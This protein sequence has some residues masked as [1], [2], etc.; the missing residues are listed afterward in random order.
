M[1]VRRLDAATKRLIIGTRRRTLP[2]LR[3]ARPDRFT[4]ADPFKLVM[5]PTERLTRMQGRWRGEL[6]LPW[7]DA[8]PFARWSSYRRR[9]H[10]GRVLAGD[11]DEATQPLDDYHLASVVDDRFV[12]GRD[13]AKIPYIKKALRKVARGERAWGNRCATAA[14]VMARCRY[15]DELHASLQR[16]GYSTERRSGELAF[17]HFLVNIGRNGEL[18]RNNDGKHRIILA[19]Q[20]GLPHL[21]ARVFIRHQGW[22]SI[23]DA[24][25]T[26]EAPDLA[27]HFADHPDLEDLVRATR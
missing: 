10:A 4:D 7:L 22:Q 24:I 5:V 17:T 9:W 11:W 3:R 1:D 27:E 20:I 18:I 19:R 2:L 6:A 21:P 15:L 13:W 14:D 26:G 16:Q 8:G 12:R 23:R 25:S